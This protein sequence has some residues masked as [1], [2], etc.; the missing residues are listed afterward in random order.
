MEGLSR[1][2]ERSRA[3]LDERGVLL[4]QVRSDTPYEPP[5][6]Y[7]VGLCELGAPEMIVFG[8]PNSGP[9]LLDGLAEDARAGTVRLRPGE[10]LDGY[11]RGGYRIR[12]DRV[13]PEWRRGYAAMAPALLGRSD[14]RLVQLVLPDRA[15]RWPDDRAAAADH[16]AAQPL[17]RRQYPWLRPVT[18]GP[19]VDLFAGRYGA[20]CT[21]LVPVIS[22]GDRWD[23]NFE[24]VAASRLADGTGV[25][26]Q[27][28]CLADWLPAGARVELRRRPSSLRTSAVGRIARVLD[29]SGNTNLRF[30]A[31]LEPVRRTGP[32]AVM[33]GRLVA[34]A[35]ASFIAISTTPSSVHI[36]TDD[37]AAVRRWMRPLQRDGWLVEEDLRSAVGLSALVC[38]DPACVCG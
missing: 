36:S 25:L 2:I 22:H 15:H 13:R 27:P 23:G 18:R 8:M 26:R 17:L 32:L 9:D 38:T 14:V 29:P 34:A 21:V 4:Q 20:D 31:D 30:R 37:P 1:A 16:L 28:P 33:L 6:L 35:P 3:I 12:V 5:W 10:L 7:T 19:E 11:L 24:A